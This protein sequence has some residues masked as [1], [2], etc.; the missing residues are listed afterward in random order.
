MLSL[1]QSC[2]L[3]ARRHRSLDLRPS[4]ALTWW[5]QPSHRPWLGRGSSA[6]SI[7]KGRQGQEK[8]SG[9]WEVQVQ[10]ALMPRGDW[11]EQCHFWLLLVKGLVAAKCYPQ[12]GAPPYS[13]LPKFARGQW[14]RASAG[15]IW[16]SGG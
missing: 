13:S 12:E 3:R 15:V 6:V 2:L 5:W 10:T 1:P 7:W 11:R 9:R 4:V 14:A 8:P 16:V